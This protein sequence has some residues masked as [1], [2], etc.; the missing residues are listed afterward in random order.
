MSESQSFQLSLFNS[1]SYVR[2]DSF[3][4]VI[5]TMATQRKDAFYNHE[6]WWVVCQQLLG[7]YSSRNS[8]RIG[9]AHN[10]DTV[11]RVNYTVHGL[12]FQ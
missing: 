1:H 6:R 3:K 11:K 8:D 10:N 4:C 9:D 2:Y 5:L 12:K 7:A